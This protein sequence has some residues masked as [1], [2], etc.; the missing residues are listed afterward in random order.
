[1]AN[2]LREVR[3]RKGFT[4]EYMAE[5]LKMPRQSS[6]ASWERGTADKLAHRLIRLSKLFD[7]TIPELFP[8]PEKEPNV[9][10]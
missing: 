3:K 5:K 9:G 2:R 10:S 7:C 1:M 4:Q 6:Y 8:L